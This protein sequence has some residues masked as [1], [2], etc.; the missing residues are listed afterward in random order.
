MTTLREA[1]G[2][3]ERRACALLGAD[4]S[5]IR[6]RSTRP[7]DRGL[8][9]RLRSLAAERRRFGY[10]RLGL[11]LAREGL[12]PNHKRLRRLYT[13][14]RL[15]VRRRG[16][17]KRA[18]GT[19]APLVMPATVN[20]RWSVD[21]ASDTLADGRRFRILCMVDDFSRECL[22]LVADTSLSGQ[23]VAR[24]LEDV[25]ARLRSDQSH[26]GYPH[27][28][29]RRRSLDE[30]LQ[31]RP[32]AQ[33]ARL[34]ITKGIHQSSIATRR[35]SG[36]TGS[37]PPPASRLCACGSPTG[38]AARATATCPARRSGWWVNGAA[39]VSGNTT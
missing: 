21:F 23:R 19:R 38:L 29:R 39:A 34:S 10:R 37:T 2:I 33:Q 24:E 13:E 28:P 26:P 20:Q 14:E 25:Q 18:I 8:R 30:R 27:R 9:A 17:R 3:S 15:Q 16:G 36:L 12:R 7:D 22:A 6:Y 35:V 31:R 5:T 4:R 1:H 32:P 11:L